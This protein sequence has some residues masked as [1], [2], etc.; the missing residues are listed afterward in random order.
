MAQ[1]AGGPSAGE[2]LPIAV[3]GAGRV[4]LTLARALSRSDRQVAVLVRT[5]RPLAD[6]STSVS[7]DWSAPL[8][9]A[10]VILIA[11]PDDAIGDVASTIAGLGVLG[12]SQVV[13]H[14]SGCR[15]AL[16]LPPLRSSGAA[17]GSWHPLQTFI[18][19]TTPTRCRA[20]RSWSKGT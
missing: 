18:E 16:R 8:A 10:G 14:T 4:G 7:A 5:A 19:A 20:R 6:G 12:A 13:L 9:A 17:L 1:V 3:I 2:R 11:V 15:G